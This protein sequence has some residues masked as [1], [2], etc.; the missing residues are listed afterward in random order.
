MDSGRVRSR[1]EV[2]T[3]L[4]A[5]TI[6]ARGV[7]VN[8]TDFVEITTHRSLGKL[9]ANALKLRARQRCILPDGYLLMF[10]GSAD[11]LRSHLEEARRLGF[12]PSRVIIVE[13]Q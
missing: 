2:Q 9:L 1:L 12:P 13:Y 4:D 7:A 11:G 10:V 6:E 5:L 3:F 8:A